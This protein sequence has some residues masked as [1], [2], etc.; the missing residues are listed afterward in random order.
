[1]LR[2][3]SASN[4]DSKPVACWV[5]VAQQSVCDRKLLAS[6]Q[7]VSSWKAKDAAEQKNISGEDRSRCAGRPGAFVSRTDHYGRPTR[8]ATRGKIWNVHP[9]GTVLCGRRGSILADH[10]THGR[11]LRGGLSRLARS[12]QSCPL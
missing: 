4:A 1:M 3:I 10:G 8:L 2:P 5:L 9:L 7:V 6:W 11:N 12:F